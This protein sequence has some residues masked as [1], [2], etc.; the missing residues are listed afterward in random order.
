MVRVARNDQ[1]VSGIPETFSEFA[2]LHERAR[3]MRIKAPATPFLAVGLAFLAIGL[4]GQDA[5]L[6]IGLGCLIAA[7]F[8]LWKQ[9]RSRDTADTK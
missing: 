2:L 4:S 5:F 6:Y 3:V 1:Y 7:G 9:V 8:A